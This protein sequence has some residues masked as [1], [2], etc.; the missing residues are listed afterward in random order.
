[1]KQNLCMNHSHPSYEYFYR[2]VRSLL[3]KRTYMRTSDP[4]VLDCDISKVKCCR[5]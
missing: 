1:M 2:F 3:K 5:S 4:I